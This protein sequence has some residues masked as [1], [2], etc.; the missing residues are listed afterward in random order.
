[1]RP[2]KWYQKTLALR[3]LRMLLKTH[4]LPLIQSDCRMYE[5]MMSVL[6]ETVP[7]CRLSCMGPQV[8]VGGAYAKDGFDIGVE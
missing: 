8:F 2:P 5:D 3:I 6:I 7:L 4:S 1:M